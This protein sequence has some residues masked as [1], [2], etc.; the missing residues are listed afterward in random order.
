MKDNLMQ[1]AHHIAAEW[2]YS[3]NERGP[4]DY[5]PHSN[6]V[7]HWTCKYGH[8]WTAKINNRVNAQSQCPYCA[9]KIPIPGQN[10]LAALYPD[11]AKE[12]HPTK[13]GDAK[14]EQFLPKSNQYAWWQ[15]GKGH[16]WRTKIYHRVEGSG[17]PYCSG[18]R[19]IPGETDFAT[20]Y[21]ELLDYWNAEKNANL[22]IT[23]VSSK[24]HQKV[25]W[26]C[27]YGH[28]WQAQINWVARS[29]SLNPNRIGCPVCA[30]KEIHEDNM[31]PIVAPDLCAEW[32]Y[33]KNELKPEEV[34]L[35]SNQVVWW[36]CG[37]CGHSWL[38]KI[39]NR[40]N[41]SGCP[42]CH[43]FAVTELNSLATINPW[44]AKEWDYERN[45][46]ETPETVAANSNIGYWWKC[47]EGH[48][49]KAVV[50]NRNIFGHGCPY[51]SRR[52]PTA[53]ENDLQTLNPA[54]AAQWHP[55]RNGDLTPA[56]VF[57][58]SDLKVW[59]QC[60]NG[61]E[62]QSI[63]FFRDRGVGCPYCSRYTPITGEN[64]LQTLNPSLAAQ[65]HTTKNGD[66]SPEMFFPTSTQK[67]WWQCEKGHT[68]QASIAAR[69]NGSGCPM[70]IGRKQYRG[71]Y[72]K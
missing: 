32:D 18:E 8:R 13:N 48:H 10:D 17:C 50:S 40:A 62:W 37:V 26:R 19:A 67:V 25:W 5:A 65:W 63:I 70:C 49:W 12:W 53:G 27:P 24:S 16:E 1:Y 41:G 58:T 60:E 35:H 3:L 7:V 28:E 30:G 45:A 9:G 42:A 55:T 38:A 33:D 2:D 29:Y 59:W 14:P 4:E 47:A 54:L 44:L 20:A 61:H 71:H 66:L 23:E 15:C 43:H 39:N 51:C 34:T 64:D 57:P 31:L 69:N 68:W 56:K 11:I 6:A 52:I 22:C 46:P 36:K 21:P 72:A